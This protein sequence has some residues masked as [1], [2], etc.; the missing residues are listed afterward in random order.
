M[1]L[2][3]QLA[4]Q[5]CSHCNIQERDD[6]GLNQSGSGGGGKKGLGIRYV[7]IS[8]KSVLVNVLQRDRTERL[9]MWYKES[10]VQ[11]KEK[12]C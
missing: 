3:G 2:K 9:Y 4:F 1:V 8:M 12:P 11:S 5:E 7:C 10:T 6:N